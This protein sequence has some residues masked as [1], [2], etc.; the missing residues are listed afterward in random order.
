MR[1]GPDHRAKIS[2]ISVSM[3]CCSVLRVKRKSWSDSWLHYFIDNKRF[4][5]VDGLR[6]TPW[7]ARGLTSWF[8]MLLASHFGNPPGMAAWPAAALR[9]H[10]IKA[11]ITAFGPTSTGRSVLK[12]KY[13]GDE[14]H[15][16][17]DNHIAISASPMWC[18][19]VLAGIAEPARREEMVEQIR[20][21]IQRILASA[22]CRGDQFLADVK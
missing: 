1:P 2:E 19:R 9:S 14:N 7:V 4:I 16:L 17:R 15:R 12:T 11:V 3:I 8:E 6:K 18:R 10:K 20:S 21:V 22:E 5:S 13:S